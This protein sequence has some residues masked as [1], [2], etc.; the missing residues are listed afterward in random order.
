MPRGFHP[1]FGSQVWF[2]GDEAILTFTSDG[3]SDH[4]TSVPLLVFDLDA[5]GSLNGESWNSGVRE[6]IGPF[7]RLS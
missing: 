2:T 3:N 1:C 4:S 6:I 5:D 7:V